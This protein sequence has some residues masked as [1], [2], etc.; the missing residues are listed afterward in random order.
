MRFTSA[1]FFSL[2][3]ATCALADLP[4]A[5]PT[6]AA[7][8]STNYGIGV[9]STSAGALQIKKLCGATYYVGKA[10][11]AS[12]TETTQGEISLKYSLVYSA[13]DGNGKYGTDV[14]IRLPITPSWDIKDLSKAE[15]IDYE[16]KAATGGV[17]THLLIGA[18]DGT[19]PDDVAKENAALSS[20]GSDPLTTAYTKISILTS[21]LA[22][23]LWMESADGAT[24]GWIA[25]SVTYTIG[26][27]KAVQYLNIQP[28]LDP[29]WNSG[30]ASFKTTPAAL[31][32]I[33]NTITIKN[34]VIKGIY[35]GCLYCPVST[36][37]GISTLLDDFT[38]PVPGTTVRK[39]TDPNLLGGYWYAY[40]DTSS[41]PAKRNDSAVGKSKILLPE[42]TSRWTPI[43]NTVAVVTAQLEKNDTGSDFLYHK[44]A[45]WAGIG[46]ELKGHNP[47]GSLNLQTVPSGNVL[48]GISFDLYAGASLS[49]VVTGATFDTTRVLRVIFKVG[50]TSVADEGQFQVNIPIHQATSGT[51]GLCVLT[52]DLSQPSSYTNRTPW[53]AEDL[54]KLSW[55]I[56]I[57]DQGDSTIHETL[58]PSSFG[59]TNV[60][61]Y[62]VTWDDVT[63]G[64]KG[65]HSQN[66]TP[67]ASYNSSLHLT[68]R[69]DGASARIEVRSLGGARIASFQEGATAQNL[70]LPV[71]LSRGTY[72]VTVQ[73]VKTRQAAMVN[74]AH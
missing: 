44:Y 42:G 33:A 51:T 41:D 60:R 9:D 5:I 21:T 73:G 40:S 35:S 45:G 68:Y 54:T 19:Y 74:V 67:R 26:I 23:P 63:T 49:S 27:S 34:V 25:D 43:V 46:T 70:S 29:A 53:S 6:V 57:E 3:L 36:C 58:V 22:M 52:T 31:A 15:S 28:I 72:V 1:L 24:V 2:A 32:V 71:A 11:S 10:S 64:I 62:G 55:E 13:E 56:R 39:A 47:D 4:V 48:T 50:R 38:T 59:V 7:D 20:P 61:L 66:P 8:V 12:L 17:T 69:V 18:K 37:A 16:I 65:L 14:G 30:G